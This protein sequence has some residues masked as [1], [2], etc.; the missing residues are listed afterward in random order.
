MSSLGCS[1]YCNRNAWHRQ[2][3]TATVPTVTAWFAEWQVVEVVDLWM[4]ALFLKR[5]AFLPA[6]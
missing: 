1:N 2:A 4:R 6:K 5:P 3:T